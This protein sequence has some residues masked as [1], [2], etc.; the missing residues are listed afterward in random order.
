V[1]LAAIGLAC[2]TLLAAASANAGPVGKE[3]GN[4]TRFG[5]G[6]ARSNAGPDE[7]GLNAGNVG[8]LARAEVH[9][10]GTV[11]S[12][13]LYV[14]GAVVGGAARDTF[15]AQTTYGIVYAID[16]DSGQVLWQFT[17]SGYDSVAGT[18]QITT[19]SPA[20]DVGRGFVYSASPD[21]QIHKLLLA[22]GQ[23]IRTDGWPA[24][25]SRD[26]AH[27]KL[28][29]PLNLAGKLL[30]VTTGGYP[31]DIPPYQG[32]VVTLDRDTGRIVRVWNALC[33][34][35]KQLL[36]TSS[37]RNSAGDV[38][39]GAAIWARSGAVVQPKTGNL[40]VSTG[41]G[42]FDGHTFWGM[43]VLMLS[44][45]ARRLLKYWT[46]A[47][48]R[49]LSAADE[50]I[51]STAPALLTENLVVQGGKHAKLWLLDLRKF[52]PPP[53]VGRRPVLG[54]ALQTL[55]APGG[56]RVLTTPAVWMSKGTRWLFVATSKGTSAYVLQNNRLARKW[57]KTTGGTSPVVAGGLLYVYDSDEGALNVYAPTT[58][59]PVASLPVGRGHWNTPVV[60]DGRI[61]LGQED[62][63][64]HVTFGVLNIYRLP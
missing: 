5:Y 42:E 27:E 14:H 7:T 47:N 56:G 3:A 59:R 63:N 51:G 15:I 55:T 32:H 6:S 28:G 40:L 46:P 19:S 41:N 49:R 29:T 48:W 8:M 45:D 2:G 9:L 43:S 38:L 25:V 18:H 1:R 35:V 31:G 57:T 64:A 30:I 10:Q 11:D 21:G 60:T 22:T 12:S 34:S 62:A 52:H 61:A 36:A 37:C 58:G 50:D 39:F 17:P 54:P 24:T 20:L 23:E 44:P 53:S 26:P 13:P 33:S 4:W 16:A